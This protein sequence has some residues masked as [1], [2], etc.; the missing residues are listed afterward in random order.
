M[1][2]ASLT[3]E[4]LS[5]RSR[6]LTSSFQ[7]DI[8]ESGNTIY[9][10]EKFTPTIPL[11]FQDPFSFRSQAVIAAAALTRLFD[12]TSLNPAAFLQAVEQRVQRRD[13]E[14]KPSV[15]ALFDQRADVVAMP[16]LCFE[17][18]KNQQLGTA[19]LQLA[20]EHL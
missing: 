20:I 7:S 6:F 2:S 15:R 11:R 12:P 13:I 9:R 8:F 10:F 16:R 17:Q 3:G 14:A 19:L 5:P 1:I 4:T 18:R